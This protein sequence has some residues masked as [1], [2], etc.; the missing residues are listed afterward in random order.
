MLDFLFFE[1]EIII[2]AESI[3]VHFQYNCICK[4]LS[5]LSEDSNKL[6]V[7]S[8]LSAF[9]SVR[10]AKHLNALISNSNSQDL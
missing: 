8:I 9:P 5:C 2:F 1:R 7:S 3:S 4:K 10:M 6:K